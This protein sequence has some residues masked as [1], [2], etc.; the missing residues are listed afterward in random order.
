MGSEAVGP[1]GLGSAGAR[2]SPAAALPRGSV[3]ALAAPTSF[4]NSRRLTPVPFAS[5]AD[6][7]SPFDWSIR[8]QGY[9]AA[10]SNRKRRDA[11]IC[12][13]RIAASTASPASTR[14]A[15]RQPLLATI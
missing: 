4:N 13:L 12:Q 9:C 2:G 1:H 11:S 7:L 5:C 8:D 14:K 15:A 6:I 3:P 10:L